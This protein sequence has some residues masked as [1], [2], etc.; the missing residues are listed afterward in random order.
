MN[1]RHEMS[2]SNITLLSYPCV[3][4][5]HWYFDT[6]GDVYMQ[7]GSP[8]HH[9]SHFPSRITQTTRQDNTAHKVFHFSPWRGS[10][11]RRSP[12][13]WKNFQGTLFFPLNISLPLPS[14]GPS[15]KNGSKK[16][17]G[18][19]ASENYQPQVGPTFAAAWAAALESAA[20]PSVSGQLW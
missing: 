9:P 19:L 14:S 15:R 12:D 11:R 13:P 17:H 6:F 8:Y 2:T 10:A 16:F 7:A 3:K 20:V 5:S 1:T 4:V 18:A